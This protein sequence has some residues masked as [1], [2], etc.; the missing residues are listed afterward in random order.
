MKTLVEGA[1][2]PPPSFR[3]LERIFYETESW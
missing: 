3:E 1:D 2:K